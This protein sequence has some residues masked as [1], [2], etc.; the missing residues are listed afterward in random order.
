[1]DSTVT[2][3]I[4][5]AAATLTTAIASPYITHRS[6]ERRRAEYTPKV[7]RS[8]QRKLCGEWSGSLIQE[9]G[10]PD[11]IGTHHLSVDFDVYTKPSGGILKIG[12]ALQGKPSVFD[13]SET[14]ST[15]DFII[16]D[17]Q[18]LKFD[19]IN[20]DSH[21]THFGTIYGKLCAS[22]NEIDGRFLAYG[23]ISEC[24]VSGGIKLRRK[25]VSLST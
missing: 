14:E 15:I 11:V 1:M 25:H 17:G 2:A 12:L 23:L 6:A 4:I 16:F 22:G 8:I 20:K 21:V 5:G 24:F 19:F 3:G 7:S 18:I 9:N 10:H 13:G